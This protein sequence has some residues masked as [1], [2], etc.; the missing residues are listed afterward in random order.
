M[1]SLIEKSNSLRDSFDQLADHQQMNHTSTDQHSNHSNQQPQEQKEQQQL[2]Q[3]WNGTMRAILTPRSSIWRE[4]TQ[5]RDLDRFIKNIKSMDTIPRFGTE[6]PHEAKLAELMDNIDAWG[7]NIFDVHNYSQSHS[8]T[9]VMYTIFKKRNL[10]ET[11]RISPQKL[12][13]YLVTLESHYLDVPYHCSIHAAD[14]TQAIHVLLLIPSFENTF[15]DLEILAALFAAAIHDVDHPGVTNQYLIN[16]DN[17]LAL[18]YNDTSVLENHS[19]AVAFKLLQNEDCDFIENLSDEQRKILRQISIDMVLATDMSKHGAIMQTIQS[20]HQSLK[21]KQCKDSNS[22]SSTNDSLVLTE[23]KERV[24]LL[25]EMLHCADL[26]NPT[27]HLSI[28]TQWVDRIMDEFHYQGDRERSAGMPISPMCNRRTADIEMAQI[29]FIQAIVEPLW[30]MWAQLVYPHCQQMLDNIDSNRQWYEYQISNRS[31]RNNTS[32]KTTSQSHDSKE[33]DKLKGNQST[34][35]E[36]PSSSN[37]S[38][39]RTRLLEHW[40]FRANNT[41]KC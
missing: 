39:R 27:K 26:S 9:S 32:D 21:A 38:K 20:F 17:E 5:H 14:V 15:T 11:F 41:Q 28:Y 8:L 18:M 10:I 16:S 6:T 23:Q 24:Q 13:N 4:S 35:S 19:L 2:L 29:G 40:P 22:N 31:S 37:S 1:T 33:Q 3:S 34:S 30:Q 36:T 25:R 12:I 7:L